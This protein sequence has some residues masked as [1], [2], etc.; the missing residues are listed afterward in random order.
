MKK[1]IVFGTFDPLHKGHIN[2]F[3]QAKGLG[4]YLT[5][6][7]SRDE[8][9]KKS[10]KR[11]SRVPQTK[12]LEA[13]RKIDIIDKVVIGDFPGKYS[14]LEK[15]R[16]DTIALGYDQIIPQTLKDKLKDYIIIRLKPYKP[17]IYKSSKLGPII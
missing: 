6:V 15:E 12:R 9:I 16:P 17:G 3:K 10:K 14:V 11:D 4:D 2:L 5:V 1:V 7:V 8:S 13:L